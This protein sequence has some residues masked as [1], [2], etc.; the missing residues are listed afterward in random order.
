M[1]AYWFFTDNNRDSLDIDNM[2]YC[3]TRQLCGGAKNIP[4][5]VRD[6][7]NQNSG[8][9]TRPAGSLV[10]NMLDSVVSGLQRTGLEILIVLDGLDEY[11]VKDRQ[12]SLGARRVPGRKAVLKWLRN[13][14]KKHENAR[15]LVAS[16]K[17]I[18]IQ[19]N[20]GHIMTLDVAKEITEDVDLF[21]ESCIERITGEDENWKSSFKTA[22]IEK[23]KGASEKYYC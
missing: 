4:E 18:D 8:A 23:M 10:E 17:E 22:M 3:I 13:F 16:R 5:S 1:L 7:W 12:G 21:I 20:L 14:G 19:E 15:V 6:L 2:L 9:G 11:P